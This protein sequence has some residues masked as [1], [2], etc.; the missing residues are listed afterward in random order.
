VRG[1]ERPV[2]RTHESVINVGAATPGEHVAFRDYLARVLR[3]EE[4]IAALFGET[5]D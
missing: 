4:Q 1:H 2:G 5:A 3:S